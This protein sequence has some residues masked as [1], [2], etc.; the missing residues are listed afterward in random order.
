MPLYNKS[1]YPGVK[2]KKK[3]P[4]TNTRIFILKINI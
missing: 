1:L 3:K 2:E 4:Q